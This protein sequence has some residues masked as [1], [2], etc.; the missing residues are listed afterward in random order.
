LLEAVFYATVFDETGRPVSRRTAAAIYTQN[1]FF[2]IGEDGWWYY[3]LNKVIQFPVIALNKLE[4]LVTA[5]AKVDIIKHEYRTVLTKSGSYFRYDSQKEDKLVSSNTIAIAGENT[6]YPFT[7]RSPGNYEIRIYV[8]GGNSYVKKEFYSYGGWG[9]DN[10][11][12]EVDNEGNIDIELDK[13]AH[14]TGETATLLFKAPFDGKML[15]TMETDKVVSYQYITVSNRSASLNIKLTTDLLPNMYVTATLIKPHDVSDIP[16]TVAHGFQNI[17]VEEKSRKMEVQLIARQAL[18]SRTHQKVTVKAA[19]GSYITLAAVDNGVLQVSGFETPDPYNYFYAKRA[20]EV[21]GF[22]M[23]PL[24]FPELRSRLSST[25]GDADVEMSK[26]TNP[27]PNKRVKVVSY[28]S[29]IAKAN[30]S[31]EAEFEFDIPQFSG[32]IRLMAVAYKNESFGSKE[33][34]MKVA[35]PIVVSTA[36]PRFLSPKDTISVPVTITNTTGKS[37]TAMAVLNV[38]SALEVVGSSQQVVVL[39]ANSEGIALFQVIAS[40]AVGAAKIIV[41]VQAL[42]E[43]YIDETDITVRPA[44]TLQKITGSGSIAGNAAEKVTIGLS[45]FMPGSSNYQLVVGRS[46]ALELATQFAYLV[47]Y[48]YGCTE[49]TV[50]AAFPQLYYG[51]LADLL[52]SGK[53]NKA[54]A[55]ANI[56]EAI[57]KIKLRQ[58]YNGGITLWDGEGT[59]HWWATV[60][61]AHFLM[62]AEKAGYDVDKDLLETLFNYLNNK[63]RNR[64]TINYYYNQN[65]QK[66]IAPKE[67]AYSL[68]ILS[69]AGRPNIGVMNYYKANPALLAL[70]SRY[71]L[72]AAYAVAGDKVKFRDLLP[73]SFTGEIA[74]AQ[75][76]GSF[77]S[78]IRDESIALN[79]L[80]DVDP[81]NG[82]IPVMAKHI[83]QQLKQRS[84]YSTQESAFSFLALG[85]LAKAAN[86]STITA[87][88]NVNGKTAGNLTSGS[89]KLNTKQLGNNAVDIVTKGDGRLYYWW[90]SEGIS[91]SGGYKEEDNYIKVR[92]KFFDRYGHIING[93]TFKQNDLL[94][95]QLSLEKSYA[96]SIDNI[97]LTDLLPAGFEIENPRTKELPGMEWIKDA[98]TPT[99]MDVRDDRINLFVNL[100]NNRQNY[101]YSV[102][103]VS[104][105]TY[106]M[107]P[108]SADAM[109]N[110]EYHS[111]NGAGVIKVIK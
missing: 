78:D 81:A 45:D 110:G 68:Y 66:K 60:Y 30:S 41:N 80:I 54:A 53:A 16:L 70:D 12:F 25:G 99:S 9:G 79:V 62:E 69:L 102:R 96:G 91:V 20:L 71:L 22:D 18:R 19:A 100:N 55:N 90:Q 14:Q 63:L 64:A 1:V 23:Y 33:L 48:P 40:Q 73:T 24:L 101:Y 21:N 56:Q 10:S 65:Q 82:Q 95:V 76:G 109:Y 11:S 93:N 89:I 35:D 13:A 57:R 104:P 67:V 42:G 74:V 44:S 84:W 50:S 103:A 31:G 6:F 36:M 39:N 97:V 75:T 43:K 26:R 37:T 88:I 92:R 52:N 5:Q 105:G 28:W 3:P 108:A 83:V 111:Y 87:T 98:A 46:P 15:V 59:E 2:G 38:S 47:E 51:D 4:Q 17:R 94:V 77:Y 34:A 106:R 72:S 58:L 49:Q 85:K 61:A 107:G 29:G 7:P 27:M 86:K 32:E 8:P